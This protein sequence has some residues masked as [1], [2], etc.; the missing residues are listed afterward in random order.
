M[1]TGFAEKLK[2]WIFGENGSEPLGGP[3]RRV[4]AIYAAQARLANQLEAHAEEAPYAHVRAKLREIAKE[5]RRSLH[6]LRERAAPLGQWSEPE[7]EPP[8]SG[9]NHWERM[10]IDLKD[11]SELVAEL[12]S[13]V[14]Q[15]TD[16]APE[17]AD[18]LRDL[19][20]TEAAHKS[21][22]LDLLMRADPQASLT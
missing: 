3:H 5:K 17:L 8:K 11:Q 14:V 12:Q 21:V 1:A 20:Q 13:A 4:A 6:I 15:L 16:V 10:S 2:R 19:A 7:V 18:F 9:R 22:I